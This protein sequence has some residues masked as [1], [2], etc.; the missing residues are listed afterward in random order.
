MVGRYSAAS[1]GLLAGGL[2]YAALVAIVPTIVLLVGVAGLVWSDP[3]ERAQVVV[4]LARVLPPLRDVL[5]AVLRDAAG[6]AGTVTVVGALALVWGASRFVVAFEDA[7]ARVMGLE[8][9]R[10]FLATNVIAFGAVA[11]MVGAVVATVLLAGVSSFVDAARA[12]GLPQFA[13]DAIQ[14]GF[15]FVPPAV[16]LVALG[17]VYRYLPIVR[18]SVRAVLPPAVAVGLGLALIAR[19]F[20][21]LAPR[22]IGLAAVVGTLA[23]AFAALAWLALSFQA[24]LLGAAWVR[25]RALAER[26]DETR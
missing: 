25:E 1:G 20:V 24:I 16:V 2:A 3:A 14:A 8:H 26:A 7:I 21:F 18:P 9:R 5:D 17:V 11:V 10:G 13:G 12:A 19:A 22:L 6:G 15:G 23:S 4:I